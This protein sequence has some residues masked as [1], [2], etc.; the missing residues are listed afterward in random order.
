MNN[1]NNFSITNLSRLNCRNIN[2]RMGIGY[3]QS[4]VRTL[5]STFTQVML[6]QFIRNLIKSFNRHEQHIKL[7]LSRRKRGEISSQWEYS[8]LRKQGNRL[9]QRHPRVFLHLFA[10]LGSG[11]SSPSKQSQRRF[12]GV[13]VSTSPEENWG[14]GFFCKLKKNMFL[15]S[16]RKW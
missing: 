3:I 6:H 13:G 10:D 8:P 2:T 14:C 1:P 5:K 12:A 11:S 15:F 16:S 7:I 9:E 4:N